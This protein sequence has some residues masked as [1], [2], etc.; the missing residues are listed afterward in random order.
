MSDWKDSYSLG[1]KKI[2][3]QHKKLVSLVGYLVDGYQ[4][5]KVKET[6][7]EGLLELEEYIIVHFSEEESL[8]N[9]WG[10][11]DLVAHRKSHNRFLDKFW[12]MKRKFEKDESLLIS[13][14]CDYIAKL[15]HDHDLAEDRMY[16]QF[17]LDQLTA[18][19]KK[20]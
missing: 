1:I 13:E 5:G 18:S 8:M 4:K 20:R 14:L 10:Y 12:E 9:I 3:D 16:A 19:L 15:F 2:D 11:P 17:F 6:L 7:S